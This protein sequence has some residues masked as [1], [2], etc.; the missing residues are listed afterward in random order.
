MRVLWPTRL[1]RL[2]RMGDWP[3]R[4]QRTPGWAPAIGAKPSA[5]GGPLVWWLLAAAAAFIA[6]AAA[7]EALA[8]ALAARVAA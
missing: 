4:S 6:S 7:H 3:V 5:I 2:P 1:Y 8:A